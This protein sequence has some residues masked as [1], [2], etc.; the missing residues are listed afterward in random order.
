M[1]LG[2]PSYLI[3]LLGS[4]SA[5]DVHSQSIVI[6]LL[7]GKVFPTGAVRCQSPSPPS[8][9]LHPQH[10]Q[11]LHARTQGA[12]TGQPSPHISLV[13]S[14]TLPSPVRLGLSRWGMGARE[15]GW[16]AV[17][18]PWLTRQRSWA[19]LSGS[20]GHSIGKTTEGGLSERTS[21]VAK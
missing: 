15:R 12:G 16:E 1:S 3:P 19:L 13:S 4:I 11:H 9:P 18:S 14:E 17:A 20:S 7:L 6:M 10:H 2:P 21:F 5:L 8:S